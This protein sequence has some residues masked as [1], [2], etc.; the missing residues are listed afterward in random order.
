[1]GMFKRIKDMKDMIEAAPG[2][3]AQAQQWG[4]VARSGLA[5]GAQAQQMAVTQ[6]AAMQAQ[7]GQPDGA[8]PGAAPSG[9]DFEP[10]AGVSLEQF[11]SVSKGVAAYGYDAS[12][13]PEV[14]A[15]QGI[16]AVTWDTAQRGWNER[17]RRNQ[18]VAE[19]FNQLYR[20]V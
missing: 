4:G 11:V 6:Q 5:L 20:G 18:A 10:V 19:R 12:K 17:I 8:Q 14:A 7:L 3:V 1:M 9:V 13:L 2:M 16:S 15:S